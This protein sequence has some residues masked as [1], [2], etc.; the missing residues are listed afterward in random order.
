MISRLR[1]L[2]LVLVFSSGCSQQSQELSIPFVVEFKGSEITCSSVDS[3]TVLSD[4][5]FYVSA[6]QVVSTDGQ[7]TDISFVA[8]AIWQQANIAMLD[9]EDGTQSC[10]NGTTELN[11]SL[12]VHLPGGAYRGLIFTIGVPFDQ[13]HRD[14][15]LAQAPLDDPAMHW[16]WRAG[17]KFLRAGVGSPDDGFWIHLGSTGCEGT[18]QNISGCSRPNRV[19][20]ELSDFEPGKGAIVVDLSA[21]TEGTVL[22]NRTPSDCS[23]GPAEEACVAP[24]AALGLDSGTVP[25]TQTVFS[26]R[27]IK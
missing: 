6:P 3:G 9:F 24:F 12:R 18:V 5:R 23:S 26:W 19:T 7:K 10:D 16:H 20:V 8:D 27:Q 1:P 2:I 15:L 14:P 11:T 25:G 21:L 4:L 17:Y 22:G 13:N